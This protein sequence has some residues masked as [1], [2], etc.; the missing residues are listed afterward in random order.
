MK[1]KMGYQPNL[2]PFFL[3]DNKSSRF[4]FENDRQ[5]STSNWT[6]NPN[7]CYIMYPDEVWKAQDASYMS[8]DIY[9]YMS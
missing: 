2:W 5:F 9:I 7:I 6:E 4:S 3:L 8:F 1:V